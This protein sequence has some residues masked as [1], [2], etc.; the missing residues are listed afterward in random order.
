M[1]EKLLPAQHTI[2]Y[3]LKIG[4]TGNSDYW[5]NFS[6]FLKIYLALFLHVFIDG[7]RLLTCREWEA[8]YFQGVLVKS[9]SVQGRGHTDTVSFESRSCLKT[10]EL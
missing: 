6:N 4:F 1:C 3:F 8:I 7:T 10:I 5:H 2:A 9:F